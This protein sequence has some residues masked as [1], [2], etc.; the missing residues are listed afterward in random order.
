M[1]KPFYASGFLYNQKTGQIL[2][3]QSQPTDDSSP[4]WSM[5]GGEGREGEDAMITFQRVVLEFLKIDLKIKRILP[6]Y[7]YFHEGLDKINYVFYAEV[8]KALNFSPLKDYIPVWIRFD[9]TLKL[10]FAS[11]TQQDIIVGERVINAKQRDIEALKI[12]A[13]VFPPSG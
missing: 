2:L 5:L 3:L 10:L 11:K 7:D 13:N 1:H 12:N 6:I 8:G 4:A 9:E